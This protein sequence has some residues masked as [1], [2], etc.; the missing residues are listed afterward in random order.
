[1]LGLDGPAASGTEITGSLSLTAQ[2]RLK[3]GVEEQQWLASPSAVFICP[4][5]PQFR[6]GWMRGTGPV[7]LTAGRISTGQ[8]AVLH[9]VAVAGLHTFG[10]GC[11]QYTLDVHHP[12]TIQAVVTRSDRDTWLWLELW[13]A[14]DG[15]TIASA[16]QSR[17]GA[18][19]QELST[20]AVAGTRYVIRVRY[21][22]AARM[23][24]FTLTVSRPS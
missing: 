13:R 3:A 6:S 1:M 7:S 21:A 24:P 5:A 19:R 12:G 18:L 10:D 16:S 15:Q 22:L 23:T 9:R 4:T 8:L 11:K 14:S 20:T 2:A 17:V